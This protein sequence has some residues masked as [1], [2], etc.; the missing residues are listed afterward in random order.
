MEETRMRYT[1]HPPRN[2]I[3]K[4]LGVL[5]AAALV[6]TLGLPSS[7]QAQSI[8]SD[9][10]TFVDAT[11]FMVT[12]TTR[13][14][15]VDNWIV[16]FTKPDGEK[17]VVNQHTTNPAGAAL[18]SS[19]QTTTFTYDR[20][21]VGTWWLQVDA[22]FEDWGEGSGDDDTVDL[23]DCPKGDRENGTAVGYTHGPWS[24]PENLTASMVPG[25]VALTWTAVKGDRGFVEYEYSENVGDDDEEWDGADDSGAM[26]LQRDPGEY[27]FSVRARGASDNDKNTDE[28]MAGDAESIGMAASVMIAVPVP[29]PTLP[30]IAALFLALLLLGSGAYLL[31]R[32]QSGGLTH[33]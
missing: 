22:C 1:V 29:T 19:P 5:V 6:A 33:A 24:A 7:T 28:G 12:W 4:S 23:E 18:G 15:G 20:N 32:R 8:A 17:V 3:T 30:E 10:V 11:G 14:T 27:T 16:T 13:F 21:D 31:R 2:R 25:G 9:G 26:V